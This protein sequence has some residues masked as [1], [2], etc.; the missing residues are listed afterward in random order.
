MKDLLE[1]YL[2]QIRKTQ[3]QKILLKTK[4]R[5]IVIINCDISH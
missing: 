3:D 2:H 1:A 5:E 4:Q